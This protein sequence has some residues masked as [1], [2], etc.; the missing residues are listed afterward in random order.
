MRKCVKIQCENQRIG[1]ESCVRL[2]Q[3]CE[4]CWCTKR[5]DMQKRRTPTEPAAGSFLRMHGNEKE[6]GQHPAGPSNFRVFLWFYRFCPY[7]IRPSSRIN[8][9]P[10]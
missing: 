9:F 4:I 7:F 2:R 1:N 10:A 3:V 5:A 6:P 8:C